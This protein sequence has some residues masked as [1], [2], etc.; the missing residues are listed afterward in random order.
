MANKNQHQTNPLPCFCVAS[1]D[2]TAPKLSKDE[3][4]LQSGLHI[5]QK[6]HQETWTYMDMSEMSEMYEIKSARNIT[7]ESTLGSPRVA[8]CCKRSAHRRADA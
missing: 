1:R 4:G 2:R 8:G 5:Y 7:R 3:N 6:G